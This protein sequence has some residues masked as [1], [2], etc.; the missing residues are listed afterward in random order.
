MFPQVD[1]TQLPVA[2]TIHWSEAFAAWL[3]E[4]G[5]RPNTISAYAQD[6]RHFGQFFEGENHQT[7][8]PRL[9]NATDVKKYF[10]WQDEAK[11]V[12]ATSR[13]RRLAS[14]KVLVAWAV[15]AGVLEYDPTVSIKRKSTETTPRDRTAEEMVR[16]QAV[17][18]DGS[19]I[20]CAGD[21]HAWL[22]MRDRVLFA[23]F[24]D[25]G[26]RIH[27]IAQ[28]RW[29]DVRFDE[30]RIHV[31]GKGG[32]KADVTVPSGLLSMLGSWRDLNQSLPTQSVLSDWN[33]ERLT[34]GQ[35]WRRI[36][37]IGEAAGIHDLK[38]HDL[39]HQ[40]VHQAVRIRVAQ[41]LS[42]AKALDAA[43]RQLR[44][45]DVKTTLGYSRVRESQIRMA[46]E[47]M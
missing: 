21:G 32:K 22:A 40:A 39:R 18:A 12:A 44:H 14:L 20:R 42:E 23:L 24:A 1:I 10:R 35:I 29:E 46:V 7:F 45:G 36:K 4:N 41:G 15:E 16:L 6:V 38:P 25:T 47:G 19:H 37:M 27:E 8:E 30:G 28:L 17:A 9:L 2:S 31:M 34:R 26:L 13:N 5:K 43:R 11:D 33:G 3:Y